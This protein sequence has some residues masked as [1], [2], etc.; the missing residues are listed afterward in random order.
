M[1]K[2][3]SG[4][5]FGKTCKLCHCWGWRTYL[6]SAEQPRD[7]RTYLEYAEHSWK[8]AHLPGICGTFLKLAHLSGICG[9]TWKLAHLPGTCGTFLKLAH[10]SGYYRNLPRVFCFF[11]PYRNSELTYSGPFQNFGFRALRTEWGGENARTKFPLDLFYSVP[12]FFGVL[13]KIGYL[14]NRLI[15]NSYY[16]RYPHLSLKTPRMF[17]WLKICGRI[18]VTK[19]TGWYLKWLNNKDARSII[20]H[21]LTLVPH[22]FP[23]IRF[24]I[25][26]SISRARDCWR[27]NKTK[28]APSRTW[29]ME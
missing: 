16:Y 9:T 21:S 10:L 1:T 27:D 25:H 5:F 8:L 4:L 17:V 22:S 28:P 11:R 3:W 23:R 12:Y 20:R 7:W 26:L 14:T 13:V 2:S 24:L 15:Y 6:E 18:P 29:Q 19:V